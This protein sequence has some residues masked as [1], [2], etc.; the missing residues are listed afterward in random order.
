PSHP[1]RSAKRGDDQARSVERDEGGKDDSATTAADASPSRLRSTSAP[2]SP[3]S[4]S[5][6]GSSSSRSA[7]GA[8]RYEPHRKAPVFQSL[9]QPL[10]APPK[11]PRVPVLSRSFAP[12]PSQLATSAQS[13]PPQQP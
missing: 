7:A 5:G 11:R 12:L 8:G 3:R 9:V 2:S 13:T 10:P 6:S 1:A 4:P